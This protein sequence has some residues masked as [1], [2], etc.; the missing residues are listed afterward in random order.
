MKESFMLKYFMNAGLISADEEDVETN[1]SEYIKEDKLRLEKT[2]N[3]EQMQIVLRL[4]S[5][6]TMHMFISRDE[7]CSKMFHLGI[8]LGMEIKDFELEE[9]C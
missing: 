9:I 6:L 4:I 1:Y 5:N 7:E 8:K 3:K 2:L